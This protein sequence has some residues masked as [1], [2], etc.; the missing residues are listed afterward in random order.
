V[1]VPYLSEHEI[2]KQAARLLAEFNIARGLR[3]TA[4]IP[5]EELLEHHLKLTLDFD[6][7]HGKLGVPMSGAEPEV[8]GALW[9]ESR[10]VFIDQSLDPIESPEKEGRYRFTLGH[11]IGHWRLHREHLLRDAQTPDMF[12][13][14]NRGPKVICRAS[15]AR[16]RVEWQADKFASSL[17][18]PRQLLY[19][20]WREEFSRGTPLSFES[21][22]ESNWAKFP[23]G[24]T[25]TVSLRAH[26]RDRFDPRAVAYFFYRASSFMAPIFNV[27]NQAMQIRL[28]DVGLLQIEE[29]SQRKIG[30]AA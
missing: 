15:Q 10:E 12:E 2:E 16:Q 27:S 4:Q 3:L 6:D 19:H 14:V 25:G 30:G 20:F 11:E 5:V 29:P 24:W 28:Q 8:L 23:V 18:M 22:Q 9:I 1:D 26:L 7:L 13:G 17:L 21:F